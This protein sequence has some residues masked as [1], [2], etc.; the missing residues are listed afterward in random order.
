MELKQVAYFLKV[1]EMGNFLAAA[2]ELY[3]SQSSLSKQ[4]I[5]LEKELDC[6]LFDRSRR[7]IALTPAGE[8]FLDYARPLFQT[9]QTMLSGMAQYKITPALNIV[10]IPVIA[11]YGIPAY[12]ARFK[13]TFPRVQYTLE[14]REASAVLAALDNHQCDLA[15]LRDNYLDKTRYTCLEIARDQFLVVLSRQH[16]LATRS[17]LS[18]TELANENFIMFDK[19][20]IVHELA[21]D[22]CRNAGFEPCIFYASL[23]VESVL[24]LVASN[25]GIALMMEKVYAYHQ[26]PQIVAIPLAETIESRL[27]LAW[28]QDTELSRPARAFVEFVENNRNPA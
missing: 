25:V 2:E 1:A 19:G 15:F 16:R 4:I 14:E 26:H 6:V 23:R 24:S 10:A 8:A 13:Q 5:A 27:V 18:L 12:L 3:I 7:K 11:Q 17:V 22:A 20:T 28:L 21:M 9:Y